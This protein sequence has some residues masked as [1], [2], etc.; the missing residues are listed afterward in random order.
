MNPEVLSTGLNQPNNLVSSRHSPIIPHHSAT[1]SSDTENLNQNN[2][3]E[4]FEIDD[5]HIA[6]DNNVWEDYIIDLS[7][8]MQGIVSL[9][10]FNFTPIKEDDFEQTP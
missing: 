3:L 1:S 6:W 4:E 10:D 2:P 8:K 7:T 5:S 9:E